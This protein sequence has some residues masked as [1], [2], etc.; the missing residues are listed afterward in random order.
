[1]AA[2]T[3]NS[4]NINKNDTLDQPAGSILKDEYDSINRKISNLQEAHL[5]ALHTLN[6]LPGE[7]RKSYGPVRSPSL[8]GEQLKSYEVAS[9][10]FNCQDDVEE[11]CRN[12]KNAIT[13]LEATRM[14]I[15]KGL[16][17]RTH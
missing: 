16:A 1:M 8:K 3:P 9:I 13:A 12:L 7:P 5:I 4:N 17:S 6:P 11:Y 14:D 15:V 10:W 2:N